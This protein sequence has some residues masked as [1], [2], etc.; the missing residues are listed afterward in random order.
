MKEHLNTHFIVLLNRWENSLLLWE[1]DSSIFHFDRYN[2]ISQIFEKKTF[3]MYNNGDI[4]KFV[5]NYVLG[6][7]TYNIYIISIC[8]ILQIII[9]QI[10]ELDVLIIMEM[11]AWCVA[12][13]FYFLCIL[14]IHRYKHYS[15][16]FEFYE[17]VK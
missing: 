15:A 16:L 1:V 6:I 13:F 14:C 10:T 3:Q 4:S 12:K 7:C 2:F 17:F 9:Q 5:C 11:S 8:L